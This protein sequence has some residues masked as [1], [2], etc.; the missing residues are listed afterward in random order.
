MGCLGGSG[1]LA[2]E[3]RLLLVLWL[4]RLMVWGW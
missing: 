4:L 3:G 1:M 2:R